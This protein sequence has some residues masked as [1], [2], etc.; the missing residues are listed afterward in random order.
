[1]MNIYSLRSTPPNPPFSLPF[2]QSSVIGIPNSERAC[3]FLSPLY[4]TL[5]LPYHTPYPYK[6]SHSF[7]VL[8]QNVAMQRKMLKEERKGKG[9]G[10]G[11]EKGDSFERRIQLNS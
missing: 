10:K 8:G 2:K 11:K 1:M 3:V 5:P 9:K 6:A 4:P 7:W